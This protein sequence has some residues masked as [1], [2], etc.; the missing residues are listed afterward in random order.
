MIS[1]LRACDAAAGDARTEDVFFAALCRAF[2]EIG[3]YRFAAIWIAGEENAKTHVAGAWGLNGRAAGNVH[4]RDL[5]R[6]PFRE[7]IGRAVALKRPVVAR[8]TIRANAL[9]GGPWPRTISAR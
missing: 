9:Y 4:S 5:E 7:L 3:G 8:R 6:E 2:G 1:L